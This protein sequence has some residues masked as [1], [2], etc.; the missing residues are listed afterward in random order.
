MFGRMGWLST[1]F[2]SGGAQ[3]YDTVSYAGGL[4]VLVVEIFLRI[5]RSQPVLDVRALGPL[6]FA[7]SE[8]IALCLTP[9]YG[10]AL[11][12]NPALAHEIALKSGKVIA[13]AMVVAFLTLLVIIIEHWRTGNVRHH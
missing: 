3:W 9:I 8:G 1:I 5:A 11:M 4:V 13:G 2:T 7:L 6:G 12:F 10:F